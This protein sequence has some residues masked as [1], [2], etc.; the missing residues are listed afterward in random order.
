MHLLNCLPQTYIIGVRFFIVA[1]TSVHYWH[2]HFN[3]RL[4]AKPKGKR[5]IGLSSLIT[6]SAEQ[7][8]A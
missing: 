1:L 5:P 2:S 6:L 7:A 8:Q 3:Y 4:K